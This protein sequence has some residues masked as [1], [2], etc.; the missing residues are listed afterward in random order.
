M[1]HWTYNFVAIFN[2]RGF[3]WEL[4]IFFFGPVSL[5]TRHGFRRRQSFG[6][7]P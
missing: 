7:S 6:E 1:T 2:L 5:V 3:A 4:G